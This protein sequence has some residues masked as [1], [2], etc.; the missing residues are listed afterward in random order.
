MNSSYRLIWAQLWLVIGLAPGCQPT[1]QAPR[2]TI[3]TAA[4]IAGPAA[5]KPP[6]SPAANGRRLDREETSA[7]DAA[8]PIT[9]TASD[10]TGLRLANV[11]VLAVQESPLAFTELRLEFDN[12]SGRT[13]EG[14][15][16]MVLPER[17]KLARLAMKV[18][19]AYQE[20]EVVERQAARLAY[21]D[22]LHQKRDPL[23]LEQAGGNTVEAR[24][25]PIAAHE[26]KRII[27]AYSE[28]VLDHV[29]HVLPLQ[30]LPVLDRV[31]I[32]IYEGANRKPVELERVNYA[33]GAELRSLLRVPLG[34]QLVR[35][36]N[37][38]VMRFTPVDETKP[39][40]LGATLLLVDTSAS[41]TLSLRRTSEQLGD[42]LRKLGNG[43]DERVVIAAFDQDVQVLLEG[44]FA[45]AADG[46]GSLLRERRAL[47][48]SN[49][50]AALAVAAEQV[51][52]RAIHRVVL[53]TDGLATAGE[54]EPAALRASVL[55][56]GRA[57]LERLDVI[58]PAGSA[59]DATVLS[60]L[61]SAG[62][63]SAGAVLDG[64]DDSQTIARKLRSRVVRD[65]PVRVEGASFV[66]PRVVSSVQ[67][68]DELIVAAEL[69]AN[70]PVRLSAGDRAIKLPEPG[71]GTPTLLARFHAEARIAALLE[72]EATEGRNRD[73]QRQI[74]ELSRRERVLSPYTSLL[75][76]ET[77]A[78]YS[79]F[80]I[81]RRAPG[82]Y[83]SVRD[84]RLALGDSPT[85]PGQSSGRGSTVGADTENSRVNRGPQEFGEAA[86]PKALG[87]DSDG[88]ESAQGNMWGEEIAEAFGAGGLGLSGTGEGGGSEGVGLGSTGTQGH[89]SGIG[90]GQGVGA[91]HGRLAGS[92]ATSAPKVRSGTAQVSGRLPPE[93][94]QRIVR[95]NFG[96]FR[97]CYEGALA[98]RPHLEGRAVVRFQIGKGGAVE[99]PVRL[100]PAFVDRALNECI[101]QAFL[102]LSF[103]TPEG[104]NV[105]VS[106]PLLLGDGATPPTPARA[107]VEPPTTPERPASAAPYRGRLGEI[108][109]LLTQK[110]TSEA[111][112]QALEWTQREPVET[113]PYFALGRVYTALERPRDAARAFGSLI[114]LYSARADIRRYAG[115][116]L[117]SLPE[118]SGLDLAI[119]SYRVARSDRPDHPSSH[120]LL[121]FALVKRSRYSEAFDVL[122]AALAR[123]TRSDRFRGVE[124]VLRDDLALVTAL[125]EAHEP[126]A[127]EAL[128]DRLDAAGVQPTPTA[129]LR[130]ILTWE[131]D[132]NDVDFHIY[133]AAGNHA[134]YSNP[135]LPGGGELYADITTGYGPECFSLP[136]PP[137][138]NPREYH[139]QAHY[140]AR[141][142]M[143]YGM[144]KLEI[145]EF[146]GHGKARFEERPYL[147]MEDHAYADLG[148]IRVGRARK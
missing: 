74:V 20:A 99:G 134:W 93:V 137:E 12:P 7:D 13:I 32:K 121:A 128:R 146:D 114:D 31:S 113:L 136:L 79:R 88:S 118:S 48:A 125:W 94:V 55:A 133:D 11:E 56:A 3:A 39:E 46:I 106:Y 51:R 139:V 115:N 42:V 64:R 107:T 59:R 89:G 101:K 135:R 17:A 29:G 102:S 112:Q 148:T 82:A 144:G 132:A 127:R 72:R 1:G 61:V 44:T 111:L 16:R 27:V 54:R 69:P 47:G 92:H 96:R 147:V 45:S 50:S 6:I 22:A 142:P 14:R 58:V 73:L 122:L 80:G 140:Y 76:L 52:A 60:Q 116:L 131:T 71:S 8:P 68:G 75:V 26:H 95:Q 37:L 9:L 129:S 98:T 5:S 25:F 18:G 66:W 38:A 87:R 97:Q 49:L 78:D 110:R 35:A 65:L 53:V 85:L 33:P 105:L 43:G 83:L 36:G 21:E 23:L 30:G 100:A 84:G 10:G 63:P 145:I 141:G 4:Q 81:A 40:A 123:G 91:G 138:T 90:S 41:Q 57:G 103:P 28:P 120:R 86:A 77:D 143:G 67:A 130:F 24:V 15:F 119:D 62:L 109:A 104:G 108:T 117:E 126:T 2:G 124:R 34:A 70:R 19:N